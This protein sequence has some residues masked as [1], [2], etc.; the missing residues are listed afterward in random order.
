MLIAAALFFLVIR[1]INTLM[2]RRKTEPE[3]MSTTRDCPYC[4]S[5]I[6]IAASRC[7]FCT[8]DVAAAVVAIGCVVG[9][10]A[11]AVLGWPGVSASA[12]TLLP[13]VSFFGFFSSSSRPLSSAL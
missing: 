13:S 2:A 6:P 1:P 5:S 12:N 10:D 3:V 4:L 7:A 9:A 11:D 8:A